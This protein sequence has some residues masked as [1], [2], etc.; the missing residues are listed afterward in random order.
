MNQF[1][2]HPGQEVVYD[3]ILELRDEYKPLRTY[4][5]DLIDFVGEI[6]EDDTRFIT[7][8]VKRRLAKEIVRE[9]EAL[10]ADY[11]YLRA[12]MAEMIEIHRA[13]VNESTN[14]VIKILTV[15]STIFPPLTFIAGV[16]GMNFEYMPELS[17]EYGYPL[18][19]T[20]MA[21]LAIGILVILR[22]KKWI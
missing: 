3:K 18:V 13:N 19:M 17:W 7:S 6:R 21:A 11:H 9:T 16:Y 4:L 5:F 14:R 8:D 1:T 22:L 15:I 12:W 10:L 20:G 2:D